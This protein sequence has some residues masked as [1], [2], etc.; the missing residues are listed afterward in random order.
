MHASGSCLPSDRLGWF[1]TK[2]TMRPRSWAN[3]EGV[4]R[5]RKQNIYELFDPEFRLATVLAQ[6]AA[7]NVASPEINHHHVIV[8]LL[9]EP[10]GQ[11]SRL[12]AAVGADIDALRAELQEM[13]GPLNPVRERPRLGKDTARAIRA[14]R[15]QARTPNEL[16]NAAHLLIGLTAAFSGWAKG[17]LKRAGVTKRAL[18]SAYKSGMPTTHPG[19]DGA[20]VEWVWDYLPQSGRLVEAAEEA[21]AAGDLRRAIG[22]Y[23]EALA[24][25]KEDDLAAGALGDIYPRL[26]QANLLIGDLEAA[27]RW[28]DEADQYVETY[29]FRP[30]PNAPD[31]S[32][33][34]DFVS[35]I[36]DAIAVHVQD[37]RLQLLKDRAQIYMGQDEFGLLATTAQKLIDAAEELNHAT[38][39]AAGRNLLGLALAYTGGADEEAE[40]NLQASLEPA[41]AIEPVDVANRTYSLATLALMRGDATG[42]LRL[43]AEAEALYGELGFSRSV[44]TTRLGNAEA[45]VATGGAMPSGLLEEVKRMDPDGKAQLLAW[46]WRVEAESLQ[47]SDSPRALSMTEQAISMSRQH[48][49]KLL[50]VQCLLE[51]G[52]ILLTME[53]ATGAATS[54]EEALRLSEQLGVRFAL[55]AQRELEALRS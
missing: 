11:A 19:L 25:A 35:G 55:D 37:M 22:A 41:D 29:R 30:P 42:A 51:H 44:T 43:A 27:I 50:L 53:D 15:G 46:A 3:I 4:A 2:P 5:K 32:D 18:K 16:I 38:G 34:H 24:T 47:S 52:R 13:M 36:E 23:Q 33:F 10:A 12:L 40:R 7:K 31:T 54:F 48:D 9:A 39:V 1:L 20:S 17:A 6:A 14:A 8:G 21:Q 49:H 45:L 26:I 28:L